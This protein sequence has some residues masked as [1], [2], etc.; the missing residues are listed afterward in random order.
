M[1]N[2]TTL[3]VEN[4]KPLRTSIHQDLENRDFRAASAGDVRTARRLIRELRDE[5]DVVVLDM[6]LEDPE[7]PDKIGTD[8]GLELLE[9][10]PKRPPEFLIFSGFSKI[11]YY[12]P[13]L[14][15]GAAAYLHK[16]EC[17]PEE[18]IRHIRALKLR[19][20]L[21]LDRPYVQNQISRIIETS[22]STVEVIARVCRE[23]LEEP[24]SAFLGA[25]FTFLIKEKSGSH[26]CGGNAALPS[27]FDPTYDTI[28]ALAFAEVRSGEPFILDANKVPNRNASPLATAANWQRKSHNAAA[29][30]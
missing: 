8:I 17:S 4:R 6:D 16:Q 14:K 26:C 23:L 29:I 18:L 19:R 11:E 12:L 15:L 20:A 7:F 5:L 25:P 21:N 28:Q 13:T 9:L 3:I 30:S 1:R 27:V 10:K 24:L 22:R 2:E